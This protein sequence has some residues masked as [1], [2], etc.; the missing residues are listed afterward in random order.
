MKVLAYASYLFCYSCNEATVNL[1]L[2]LCICRSPL[3][4]SMKS[5]LEEGI[6][7]YELHTN[8]H[9]RCDNSIHILDTPLIV[10]F[11]FFPSLEY[12]LLLIAGY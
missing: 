10:I 4:D 8:R 1:C 9:G 6:S 12:G 2:S 7:L 5:V 3:P 11:F